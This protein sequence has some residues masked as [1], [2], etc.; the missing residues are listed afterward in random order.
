VETVVGGLFRPAGAKRLKVHR[1]L[2]IDNSTKG[3]FG[4]KRSRMT[5]PL[6]ALGL[7]LVSISTLRAQQSF[8]TTI[9][10]DYRY[11]LSGSGPIT[12]KPS[13]PQAAYLNNQFVFR[14]AYFTYENKISDNLKFRFRLDADNTANVTGV[15]LADETLS[16]K[17]DDR[18]RPFIKHLYVQ[19]SNFLVQGMALTVGM[20]ETLTFKIAEDK[21]GYRSVAKTLIDGYKDITGMDIGASSADIGVSLIGSASKYVRYGAQVVNGSGYSHVENNQYKK[22]SGR[23]QILPVAGFS[24]VGYIDYTRDLPNLTTY[25]GLSSPGAT[26]YKV[27]A[28]FEMIKDLTLGGE[29]FTYRKDLNR[30]NDEM[31]N[32]SG[33]SVFGHYPLAEELSVFARYDGYEPNSL[34]DARN[35]GLLIAGLDWFPMGKSLR[36]QPNVWF[37]S[38]KDATAY[39]AT[40]TSNSDVYFNLTFFMSF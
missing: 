36:L 30:L 5:A 32:V 15:T 7:L 35:M 26:T 13:D 9:Y 28:F 29:W 22:F 4:M 6:I 39:K 2:A 34:N 40:A 33:W 24:L 18:F 14:R 25:P 10:L 27:A 11:F 38:Y 23:L 12:L 19:W 31:Y 37:I 1:L 3:D 21:W 16:T 17:K 20:E 8:N